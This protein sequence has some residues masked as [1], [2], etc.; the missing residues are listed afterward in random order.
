MATRSYTRTEP[1]NDLI[2]Y[3]WSGLLNGDDG[4]PQ[5]QTASG[6]RVVQVLGT[7]G[8]GGTVIIEGSTDGGNWFQLRDPSMS[9]ISF[10]SAGLK[11]IT[12]S[13]PILR[14]RVTAGDGTTNLTVMISTRRG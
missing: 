10:T 8:A 13:V 7:F 4:G 5:R 14:P 2:L 6:D 1:T 11:A 12:E 3:A 9:L